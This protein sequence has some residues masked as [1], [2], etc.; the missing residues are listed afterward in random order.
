MQNSA[1]LM[2]FRCLARPGNEK[3]LNLP[4][5]IFKFQC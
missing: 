5:S 4:S 2:I 1:R 3:A